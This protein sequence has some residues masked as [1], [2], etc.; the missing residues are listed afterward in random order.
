MVKTICI[1]AK[2]EQL[3]CKWGNKKKRQNLTVFKAMPKV[4][5]WTSKKSKKSLCHC[6]CFFRP[7]KCYCPNITPWRFVLKCFF[8]LIWGTTKWWVEKHSKLF[9]YKPA[10]VLISEKARYKYTDSN[11]YSKSMVKLIGPANDTHDIL[12][13]AA[14]LLSKRQ[15][16]QYFNTLCTVTTVQMAFTIHWRRGTISLWH[17]N[18]CLLDYHSFISR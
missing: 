17:I 18:R 3:P 16:H 10:N 1:C 4:S 9:D 8:F 11:D 13:H 12:R 6:S 7:I 5:H 14:L 2:W 15:H